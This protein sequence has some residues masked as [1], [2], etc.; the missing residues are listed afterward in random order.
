MPKP[1]GTYLRIKADE[2]NASNAA[3]T[4]KTVA[5]SADQGLTRFLA[6]LDKTSGSQLSAWHKE[7]GALASAIKKSE[8]LAKEDKV[9]KAVSE[10]LGEV[11]KLLTQVKDFK[12]LDSALQLPATAVIRAP[13]NLGSAGAELA[14]VIAI[15]KVLEV[16]VRLRTATRKS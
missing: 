10:V 12:A 3:N 9:R 8:P 2:K 5:S 14:L 16:L 15:V 13:Q 7:M 11:Q 1:Q 6:N 4:K